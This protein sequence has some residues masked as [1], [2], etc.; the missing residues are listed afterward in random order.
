MQMQV[1][2]CSRALHRS[3]EHAANR[4]DGQP[5]LLVGAAGMASIGRGAASRAGCRVPASNTAG[6]PQVVR[7]ALLADHAGRAV[8]QLLIWRQVVGQA[9]CKEGG[10]E[11]V[12]VHVWCRV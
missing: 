5:A 10:G 4:G 6:S 12:H 8:G 3:G 11:D 9:V 2:V 7:G 1:V